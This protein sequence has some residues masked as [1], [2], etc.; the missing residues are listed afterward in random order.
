MSISFTRLG[1]FSV[2]ISSNRF[3]IPCS[4]SSLSGTLMMQMLLCLMLTQRLL[5]LPSFIFLLKFSLS[6]SALPLSY[7]NIFI[8]SVL[9]SASGTLLVSILMNFFFWSFFSFLFF[10]SPFFL[11]PCACFYVLGRFPKSPSLCSVALCSRCAVGP[12]STVL[13]GVQLQAKFNCRLGTSRA[14]W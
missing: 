13:G 12:R 6:S 5:K 4:L 1:K 10:V 3:S 2:I 14:T 8:T 11:P 9:N 7:L